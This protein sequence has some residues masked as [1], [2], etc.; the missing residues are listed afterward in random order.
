MN[1]HVL[2][3]SQLHIKVKWPIFLLCY[4]HLNF[5]IEVYLIRKKFN[6]IAFR[7][8]MML[9]FLRFQVYGNNVL[10]FIAQPWI[11]GATAEL[12]SYGNELSK[13]S[14]KKKKKS[15]K[16]NLCLKTLCTGCPHT[17]WDCLI[18]VSICD[19]IFRIV[20][21][22]GKWDSTHLLQGGLRTVISRELVCWTHPTCSEQ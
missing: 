13:T 20:S 16:I 12:Q 4:Y 19:S 22:K 15:W 18:H 2:K 6:C 8:R 17:L 14:K 1:A 3:T 10:L 21:Q 11:R 5:S 9:C 7:C